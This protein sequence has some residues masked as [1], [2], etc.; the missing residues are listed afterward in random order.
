MT[1]APRI[2]FLDD[3]HVLRTLRL[4]L[5]GTED[6]TRVR[7]FFAPEEP[8]LNL[9]FK[10]AF[11][12]QRSQGAV[13]GLA[14]V[15]EPAFEDA[16][17]IVFRRGQISRSLLERHQNLRL[18]QRLGERS[19]DIDLQA[20]A[21]HRVRVSC[22]RRPSLSDTAEH[23]VLLM[24]ALG[25]KLLQADR[26]VRDGKVAPGAGGT[27]DGTAYNWPGL[28]GI[29]GIYGKTLG[30]VGL[31]EVGSLLAR[32]AGALGMRVRYYKRHRASLHEEAD[33]GVEYSPP[34]DLLATSDYVSLHAANIPE[35]QGMAD[36][37]F[38]SAMKNG[39]FFVNTS[40]GKLVNEDA[41]YEA[42][43]SGHIAGAGLDVHATEPRA[44]HDRFALL[45]NVILTP[46]IAGGPRSGIIV[47]FS[48]MLGNIHAA[49]SGTSILDEVHAHGD[50]RP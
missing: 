21:E 25:K 23:T 13:I 6:D 48:K 2:L 4:I 36:H 45:D 14:S 50:R 41:L 43:V 11:G 5:E 40:R 1:L 31:G 18:V 33:L 27:G 37:T 8:D 9:L 22:L 28:V 19:A 44:G 7:D 15:D 47:E 26:A 34:A 29:G 3:D 16:T 24:M 17:A 12:L 38:F 30:I 32:I 42:L 49:L 35:N 20:A 10:T 46:H 39:A